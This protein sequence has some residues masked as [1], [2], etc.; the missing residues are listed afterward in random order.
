MKKVI[1]LSGGGIGGIISAKAMQANADDLTAPDLIVGTSVGSILGAYLAL[2]NSADDC[3]RVF[4]GSA[5]VIFGKKAWFPPYYSADNTCDYLNRDV[6]RGAR[7]KDLH[8]PLVISTYDMVRDKTIYRNSDGKGVNPGMLLAEFIR[9][10]FCAPMYFT[11]VTVGEMLQVLTDGGV[12]YNNFPVM[13]AFA[14]VSKRGWDNSPLMVYMFGTGLLTHKQA[15]IEREFK[16]LSRGNW[17]TEV[18]EY[19]SPMQGGAARK[20]SYQ[21]QID[22]AMAVGMS[23]DN[24]TEVHY[25]DARIEKEYKLDS[26]ADMAKL[27]GLPVEKWYWTT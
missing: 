17:W 2:G 18:K 22:A 21:E 23:A 12:G 7:V 25:F 15:D 14:E 4:T 20:S 10:S 5:K 8:V 27:S 3:E 9:P 26:L 19:L 6:F 13:P 1:I 16:R 11:A 24:E